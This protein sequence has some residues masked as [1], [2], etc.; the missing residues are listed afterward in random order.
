MFLCNQVVTVDA[1]IYELLYLYLLP[2]NCLQYSHY[3]N[4]QSEQQLGNLRQWFNQTDTDKSGKI[5]AREL[6][7]MKLPGKGAWAGSL[8]KKLL[9]V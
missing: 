5:D 1:T 9:H 6:A 3:Y 2:F 4:Q 8:L 7:N